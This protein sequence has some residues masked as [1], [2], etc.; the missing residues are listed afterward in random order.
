MEALDFQ[1]RA[2]A[3]FPT[4]IEEVVKSSEIEGE[5]LDKDQIQSSIAPRL[6]GDILCHPAVNLS[7]NSDAP[8]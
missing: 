5:V 1:L 6:G 4:L 3:V 7:I 8:Q 2:E